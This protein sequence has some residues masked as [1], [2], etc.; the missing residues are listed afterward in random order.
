[1]QK[2]L[3]QQAIDIL[4]DNDR[5]GYTVPT[6]R[7]YPYQ[8]NWDSVFA[9]LGFATFDRNRAWEEIETLFSGQW[10]DGML[11]HIIFHKTDPDYFPGPELWQS[12][13]VPP[14]SGHSQPPVAA[15]AILTLMQTG[16]AMDRAR[17]KALLPKLIG[18]HR[19]FHHFR[20]PDDTGVV[21]I[22]HPWESGRDNCPDWDVGM[23]AIEVPDDLGDLP[24]RDITHVDPSE[25]PTA[26]QYNRY[27]TIVKFGH[28]CRWDHLEI[29]RNGPFFMVDPCVQ[30]ALMR[31]DHDLAQLADEFGAPGIR[32]EAETWVKQAKAGCSSFWS[33]EAGGFVARDLRSGTLST[34]LTNASAMAFYADAGT[35]DQQ[36]RLLSEISAILEECVFGFPSWDPRDSRFESRRYWRG[37]IWSVVNYMIAIG[38]AEK[39]HGE[40]AERLRDDTRRVVEQSGFFEYFDP[41]TGEGLG[42]KL[43]TWTAAI[44]LAWADQT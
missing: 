18:Y 35:E 14:S 24:R 1:M 3:R 2:T 25:R 7:L 38:L 33:E 21:G 12:N 13:T 39:G 22:I 5:G 26:E 36:R 6:A 42:G 30:F 40:I 11:P 29:A 23:N 34:A 17:A 19:W 9:A 28:D 32:N 44:H 20:D 41:L 15:S 27:L 8:W 16:G 37:P 10:E 43:F 4:R 31:A